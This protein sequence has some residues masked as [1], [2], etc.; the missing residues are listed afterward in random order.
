MVK[1]SVKNETEIKVMITKQECE[2]L[3]AKAHEIYKQVNH[4]YR[5][6]D[7]LTVR[8]RIIGTKYFLQYKKDA[9]DLKL[10]GVKNKIEYSYDL[11]ESDYLCIRNDPHVLTNYINTTT[12]GHC[13]P[14]YLGMLETLRGNV[15]LHDEMPDAEI[16]MSTYNGEVDYELEWEINENLY[17]KAVQILEDIGISTR[18]REKG[19][20]KC[21]RFIA[22][23][24]K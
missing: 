1:Y 5:I 6:N 20:S 23:L 24:N 9:R 11:S 17:N 14:I 21:K 22:S 13:E 19:I 7:D 18:N 10:E 3:F 12:C 8:I 15:M 16:D 2:R 4:Y